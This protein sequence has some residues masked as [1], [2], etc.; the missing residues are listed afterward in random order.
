MSSIAQQV[1]S[2]YRPERHIQ[3]SAAIDTLGR[4]R[5]NPRLHWTSLTSQPAAFVHNRY[6]RQHQKKEDS[7]SETMID[8][9][10]AWTLP[11]ETKSKKFKKHRYGDDPEPGA[12]FG[13]VGSSV[14]HTSS[15]SLRK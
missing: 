6:S 14:A 9:I 2:S 15:P 8:E 13:P 3:R 7:G 1:K 5:R 4:I 11:S 12:G 10:D